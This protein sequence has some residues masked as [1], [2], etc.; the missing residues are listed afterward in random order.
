MMTINNFQKKEIRERMTQTGEAYSIAARAVAH[1]SAWA[2]SPWPSFN[3]LI[4][5]INPEGLYVFASKNGVGK[6]TVAIAM[7]LHLV[8]RGG[9]AYYA[10]MEMAESELRNRFTMVGA[11]VSHRD[12]DSTPLNQETSDKIEV[13]K[14]SFKGE[15]IIDEAASIQTV[16]NVVDKARK[17]AADRNLKVIIVDYI[18]MLNP[19]FGASADREKVIAETVRKLH[20]LTIELKVP[21]IILSQINRSSSETSAIFT[22]ARGANTELVQSS[23]LVVVVEQSE[24]EIL[25]FNVTKNKSKRTGKVDLAVNRDLMQISELA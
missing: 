9:S 2:S 10:N 7:A 14:A 8:K 15:I 23:Q 20:L 24:E 4:G 3:K 21:I 13:F 25:T 16:D 5:K 22:H 18:Q 19:I 6:S 1:E 12:L 17:V 11:G